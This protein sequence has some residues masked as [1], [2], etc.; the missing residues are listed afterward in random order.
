MAIRVTCG[1]C[2]KTMNVKHEFAG[3]KAKCPQCG[4][5][6]TIPATA[7]V[8][9]N[10][11]TSRK[12]I[13][14]PDSTSDLPRRP[15]ESPVDSTKINTARTPRPDDPLP[16]EKL[17]T[18]STDPN[19]LMREILAAFDGDFERVKPTLGYRL[20][21]SVVAVVMVLLPILYV[22]LVVAC[23]YLLYW[24]ATT[25][26]GILTMVRG[27]HGAKF[28]ALVY[29]SPL[30][31]GGIMILFMIKPLFARP[32]KREPDIIVP[33]GEE[34]LLH[35][36]VQRLCDEV[37]ASYPSVIEV[38]CDVNAAAFYRHGWWSI[39][40]GDTG[41]I[42]G[43]PLLSTLNTR[44]IAGILAHELGHFS[45]GAGRRISATIRRVNAWFH[46]VIYERDSWDEWL[47]SLS[48]EDS[49]LVQFLAFLTA[50]CVRLTR[51]ILWLMMMFGHAVS[52]SLQRQMEYDADKYEARLAG[53]D[54][55]ESSMR[56]FTE[57]SFADMVMQRILAANFEQVGLP[58]NLPLCL[59]KVARK[60][61]AEIAVMAE[62]MIET[63]R[64]KW[65]DSHPASRDRIA[66]AHQENAEGIFRME[67][68][69]K[70]LLRDF[71]K[72]AEKATLLYYKRII[73]KAPAKQQL[74]PTD[75]FLAEIGME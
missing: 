7:E 29:F 22:C 47:H 45:Q 35:S 1:S 31:I 70:V 30:V 71:T 14:V 24:H 59:S 43:L 9:E 38:N 60:L 51:G 26:Y 53:S 55:F 74:R 68:P 40:R 72:Y 15:S 67:R 20:A 57:L 8:S 46:R 63:E 21:T 69:G 13:E 48:D 54:V 32:A 73:G 42:I 49:G 19:R 23:G 62:G 3:R 36:F 65:H 25:N 61:P 39:L 52:C 5:T 66:A 33:F 12:P 34:P 2:E 56:R 6:L 44:Q 17:A 18:A 50:L 10:S 58:D 64:T 75:Q 4:E 27:R 37:G 16:A 41:L 28:G 11:K